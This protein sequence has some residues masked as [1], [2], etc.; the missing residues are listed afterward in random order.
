MLTYVLGIP[1]KDI[2]LAR[3]E[4]GKPYLSN[5]GHPYLSFNISHQG[6]YAVLAA[7][8]TFNVGIDVMKIEYPSKHLHSHSIM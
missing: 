5:T 8:S 3:T 7:D 1:Y 6:D 2:E 4:K